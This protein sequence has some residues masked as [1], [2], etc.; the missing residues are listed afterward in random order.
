MPGNQLAA[1]K[2]PQTTTSM[3]HSLLPSVSVCLMAAS[4][5]LTAGPGRPEPPPAAEYGQDAA[6]AHGKVP[7]QLNPDFG[8]IH[9]GFGRTR[10]S[11]IQYHGGPLILGGNG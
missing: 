11:L 6:A 3:K 5:L 1:D 2:R 9:A 10:G 4:S 8:K 7:H